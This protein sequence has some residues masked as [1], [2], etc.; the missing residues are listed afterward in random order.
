MKKFWV[1][2]NVNMPNMVS[3]N[4]TPSLIAKSTFFYLQTLGHFFCN[5]EYYTRREG[6]RSYLLIY[7]I[8]GKGYAKY[9]GRSYETGEGQV[10]L[11]DC[12]N[13]QE[14]WTDKTELWH[15]KWIHFNG[16]TS[17]GYFNLIYDRFGPVI[18]MHGR[19]NL[20]KCLNEIIEQVKDNDFQLEVNVS[21]LI[22]EM[23]SELLV[24]DSQKKE[25][26]KLALPNENIRSSLE[27]VENNYEKNISLKDMASA[28]CCSEFHFSRVF[29]RVTGYS[30]YEYLLKYRINIAKSHLKDGDFTV[31]E[32]AGLVG[33]GSIS[34][35]IR[36]FKSLE[37][38]TPLK[39]RKYWVG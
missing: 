4:Y 9:R 26:L 22:V 38:M 17:S 24:S 2:G 31:E 21:R 15:F 35:F 10:L 34:N 30:P 29:K 23:L 28:A 1:D 16:S 27:F 7:T 39:Y 33:F 11:M 25:Q 8:S 32:I 3:Y 13:Y 37:Q 18:D 20:L 14:Y 6:Y 12:Y 19:P 5:S 36:T